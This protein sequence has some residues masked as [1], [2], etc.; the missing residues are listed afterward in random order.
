M[1]EVRV[2]FCLYMGPAGSSVIALLHYP[3]SCSTWI[4]KLDEILAAETR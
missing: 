3:L 2:P 1:L 4:P